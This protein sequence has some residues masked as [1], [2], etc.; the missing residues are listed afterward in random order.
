MKRTKVTQ[1]NFVLKVAGEGMPQ[2]NFPSLKGDL[3]IEFT[4]VIPTTLTADQKTG[5]KDLLSAGKPGHKEL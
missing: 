1:P 3:F 4:V 5:I 2:H